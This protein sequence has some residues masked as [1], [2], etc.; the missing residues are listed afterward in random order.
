MCNYFGAIASFLSAVIFIKI[1]EHFF[2]LG[3]ILVGFFCLISWCYIFL[4][5]EIF[6]SNAETPDAIGYINLIT[7]VLGVILLSA[8]CYMLI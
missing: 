4:S 3:S 2:L 8:G 1:D 7:N 5:S 6:K